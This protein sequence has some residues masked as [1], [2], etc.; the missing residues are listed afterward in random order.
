ML[1]PAGPVL[2]GLGAVPLQRRQHDGV[3]T[4]QHRQSAG[5]LGGRE[6][7]HGATAGSLQSRDRIDGGDDDSE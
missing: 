3:Q 6:V 5:G 2:P 4:A 1:H 7:G